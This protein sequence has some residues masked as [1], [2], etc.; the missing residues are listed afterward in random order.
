MTNYLRIYVCVDLDL[1]ELGDK[2]LDL[3]FSNT[4]DLSI[5]CISP[6]VQLQ[7][8]FH[9]KVCISFDVQWYKWM[10]LISGNKNIAF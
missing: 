5:S 1:I 7:D 6:F 8:G 10:N 9:P 3:V 2:F 4:I